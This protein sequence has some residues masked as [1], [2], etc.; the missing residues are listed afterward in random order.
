[1]PAFCSFDGPLF[2]T[3]PAAAA[4]CRKS[5][6]EEPDS[7]FISTHFI[8]FVVR[9]AILTY[10]KAMSSPTCGSR[11]AEADVPDA[12]A[13][14]EIELADAEAAARLSDELGYPASVETMER[15]IRDLQPLPDHAVFVACIA[16]TVVGWIDVGITRH[17]QADAYGEIGGLVVS[18]AHRS[19]GIGRSL[20][21]HAEQW[22]RD[23]GFPR[24]VVRSQIAREAAHRFYLREGYAKVKTSAVFSKSLEDR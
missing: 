13:V 16:G 10:Q 9:R 7:R 14:R 23:R 2:E 6:R 8:G 20:L 5:R 21:V 24:V 1:L 11:N 12:P 4:C 18:D 22:L 15:R 17:L 3:A 19:R